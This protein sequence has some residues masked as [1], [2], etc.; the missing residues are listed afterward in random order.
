MRIVLIG[1]KNCGKTSVGKL[2]AEKTNTKFI[3][4]DDLI[5]LECRYDAQEKKPL[6]VRQIYH[7]KGQLFFR[8]LEKKMISR[9]DR[10]QDNIIATGGGSIL[11]HD[12]VAH[13]KTLGPLIYLY[14]SFPTLLTRL[15]SQPVP[16]FLDADQPEKH[17]A[18]LYE[19]RSHLYKAAADIEIS[20]EEKSLLTVAEE[21][22]NLAR[23]RHG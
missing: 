4:T 10:G 11:D 7:D 20:T 22:I 23:G 5:E 19:Q 1:F 21:I 8:D 18:A 9:L 16:A 2:I 6:S 17:L 3:D 13:L 15:R 12:N 14:A